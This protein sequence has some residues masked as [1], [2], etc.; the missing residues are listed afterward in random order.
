M[1]ILNIFPL[2]RKRTQEELSFP[3]EHIRIQQIAFITVRN[4]SCGKVM[5]SQV[6]VIL[7]RGV[8]KGGMHGKGEACVAKA[9]MCMAKRGHP[10]QRGVCGGGEHV[11]QRG[12]YMAKGVHGEGAV[13]VIGGHA[14]QRG[15]CVAKGGYAW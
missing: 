4:S 2:L 7:C 15:A 8:A 6:S 9:G 14:W 5:F 13:C 11:W 3:E 12:V 10:W 1:Y